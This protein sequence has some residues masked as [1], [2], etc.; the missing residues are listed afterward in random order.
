MSAISEQLEGVED[1]VCASCSIAAID[2]VTLKDCNGGCDLV[3]YCGDGR[4]ENHRKQHEDECKQ[5]VDEIHD[6]KLFTQPD[7]SYLG[8]C[9]LCCLPLSIDS[10]KSTMMPCCCKWICEGCN[11]ANQ[12][13]EIEGGLEPRCAFCREP[14]PES[15]EEFDKN[16][17]NRIKKNDPVAMTSQAKKHYHEGEYGKAFEYLK[18][19][20]ELGDAGAHFCL[21][22]LY[23]N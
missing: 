20:A 11:Y 6:K 1:E 13:R 5:R 3:K 19:A 10:S 9:P 16:I 2:D 23:R 15:Q 12:K 17:M 4:Q 8:E 7:I 21:G 18:N 14:L 22:D